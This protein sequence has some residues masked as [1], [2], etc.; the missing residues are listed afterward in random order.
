MSKADIAKKIVEDN[1]RKR[2]KEGPPIELQ[3]F[4]FDETKQRWLPKKR[5]F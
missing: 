5:L 1:Q 2:I 4:A 3:H